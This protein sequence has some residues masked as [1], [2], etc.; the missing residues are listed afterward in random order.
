MHAWLLYIATVGE[1]SGQVES[2][3][4]RSDTIIPL[5]MSI[6]IHIA[7]AMPQPLRHYMDRGD[8]ISPQNQSSQ[9]NLSFTNTAMQSSIT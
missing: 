4:D 3:N 9:V 6:L 5:L 8:G 7:N 1:N 2:E